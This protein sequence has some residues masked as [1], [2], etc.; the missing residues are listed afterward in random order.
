M[1]YFTSKS[2]SRW[3]PHQASLHPSGPSSNSSFNEASV[4]SLRDPM[5]LFWLLLKHSSHWVV[6]HLLVCTSLKLDCALLGG[7]HHILFICPSP[8]HPGRAYTEQ[9]V[10]VAW[11]GEWEDEWKD[12][13]LW[14]P[15]SLFST[16]RRRDPGSAISCL[17]PVVSQL[18]WMTWATHYQE[19]S[20]SLHCEQQ[21]LSL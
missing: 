9:M 4:R 8:I 7:R 6:A 12:E 1:C 2:H 16:E 20:T 17:A 21:T 19:K 15:L 14:Q 13:S 3:Q 18:S 5:T 11:M 10:F